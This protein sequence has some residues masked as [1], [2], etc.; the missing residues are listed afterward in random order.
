MCYNTLRGAIRGSDSL[1]L[2]FLHQMAN[3][4][5]LEPIF[6]LNIVLLIVTNLNITV[7]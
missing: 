4:P 2:I 5:I 3:I 6:A 7:L 1:L